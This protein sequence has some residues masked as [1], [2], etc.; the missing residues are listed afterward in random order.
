[1]AEIVEGPWE[2]AHRPL[3]DGEAI[4]AIGD[5]HGHLDQLDALMTFIHDRIRAAYAPE[6]VLVVFLGD[7]VDRGP[8]P[9]QCLD[10]VANGLG[11]DGVTEV[12]LRG[13]HEQF[14]MDAVSGAGSDEQDLA[15][16]MVNGGRETIRAIAPDAVLLKP[17]AM[18]EE[19]RRRLG[20]ARLAFMD[21]MRLFFRHDPYFFAHAGID[22]ARDLDAQVARD[23]LWIREPFLSG[24]DWHQPVVVVHGHTP[25][26]PCNLPHRIGVDSGIY[27]T[28]CLTA[29]EV[30]GAK[31]RFVSASGKAFSAN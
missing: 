20:A 4:F 30:N 18:A 3:P 15:V 22:P 28:G 17:S 14:L 12:V 26:V 1:M 2:P 9:L 24:L 23:L 11:I 8:Q 13:N 31:L 7:Y 6:K 21:K 27:F 25:D 29:V 5:I 10:R 19:L 16:W